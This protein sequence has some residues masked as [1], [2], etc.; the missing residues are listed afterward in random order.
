M[1]CL[2]KASPP[3]LAF[4]DETPS[5]TGWRTGLSVLDLVRPTHLKSRECFSPVIPERGTLTACL[6]AACSRRQ[7]L[8]AVQERPLL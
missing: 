8:A 2:C 4:D 5:Q 6:S 3:V 1:L 7:R